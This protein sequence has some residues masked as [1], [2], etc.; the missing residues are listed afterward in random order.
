MK[1][2]I[3]LCLQVAWLT[4]AFVVLVM[5]LNLCAATDQACFDAGDRMF[6]TMTV[7]SFPAGILGA[8]VASSYLWPLDSV[9]QLNDY[10]TF[11]LMMAGAGYLQWFVI[12]PRIF[13]KPKITTL[14]LEATKTLAKVPAVEIP[15][16]PLTRKRIRRIPPYDK[17]GRTPLERAMQSTSTNASA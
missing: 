6:L 15:R 7:L 11:W 3:K 16:P 2:R 10:V 9:D 17:R 1:N 8:M 12:I 13:A 14:N 5:G 4:S